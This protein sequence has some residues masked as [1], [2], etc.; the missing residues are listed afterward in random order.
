MEI[1]R[2]ARQCSAAGVHGR[3]AESHQLKDF[4][5]LNP[6]CQVRTCSYIY[7][8]YSANLLQGS[9][10]EQSNR[11]VDHTHQR[12]VPDG[13]TQLGLAVPQMDRCEYAQE[14][15]STKQDHDWKA[16]VSDEQRE[17]HCEH[18]SSSKPSIDTATS[19]AQRRTAPIEF[20]REVDWSSIIQAVAANASAT[21]TRTT[22]V[23]HQFVLWRVGRG[24]CRRGTQPQRTCCRYHQ[25]RVSV[26][27]AIYQKVN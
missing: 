4:A 7:V 26:A 22:N 14:Q 21:T 6:A 19:Q 25:S 11:A 8:I 23:H 20:L 18:Y 15:R 1:W 3:S 5:L 12:E 24:W 16:A 27:E 9:W 2:R 13:V 17:R 10:I